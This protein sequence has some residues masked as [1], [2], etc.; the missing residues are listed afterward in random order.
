MET[1]KKRRI[2]VML[3]SEIRNSPR[4]KKQKEI[5]DEGKFLLDRQN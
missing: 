1:G 5:E 3:M 4:N 2:D